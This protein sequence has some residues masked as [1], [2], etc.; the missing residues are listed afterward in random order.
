VFVLLIAKD[1]NLVFDAFTALG[2]MICFYYGLTGFACT[3]YYRRHVFKSAK[4]FL[5]IGVLPMLGG[6]SLTYVFVKS[7]I[8]LRATDSGFAG[9]WLGVGAPFVIAMITFLLGAVL[10]A[11]SIPK[12][13]EY[14]SRKP[15]IVD[16][17]VFDHPVPPTES[18][19]GAPV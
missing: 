3:V 4:N 9:P 17:K 5:F 6:I 8:D 13:R 15:S 10:L 11:I 18:T 16:P 1:V 19:T 7:L 14:F 2:L 12:Y